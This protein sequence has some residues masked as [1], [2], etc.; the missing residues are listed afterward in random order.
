MRN[1]GPLFFSPSRQASLS[2]LRGINKAFDPFKNHLQQPPSFLL[3]FRLFLMAKK[4]EMEKQQPSTAEKS[5]ETRQVDWLGVQLVGS[6]AMCRYVTLPRDVTDS[7]WPKYC[8]LFLEEK[9]RGRCV[10]L[11]DYL[12]VVDDDDDDDARK[13]GWLQSSLGKNPRNDAS[14]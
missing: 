11:L 8:L 4:D 9:G 2:R 1:R 3:I 7:I 10:D 6:H 5:Y 14:G 13:S 12:V